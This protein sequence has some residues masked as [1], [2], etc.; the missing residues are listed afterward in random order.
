MASPFKRQLL[1]ALILFIILSALLI[2]VSPA[3]AD[4]GP[5]PSMDF[6]FVYEGMPP[7]EIISGTLLE[8]EDAACQVPKPLEELGPQRFTC[9]Q[10]ACHSMAYSYAPY[11]KLQIEFSDGVTPESG[12]FQK[13]TFNASYTVTVSPEGMTAKE[14]WGVPESLMLGLYVGIILAP[15]LL[16]VAGVAF[17]VLLLLYIMRGAR[18]RVNFGESRWLFIATWIVAVVFLLAGTLFYVSLPILVAVEALVAV[19]GAQLLKASK[20]SVFTVTLL[21]NLV[22]IPLA[23]LV[24]NFLLRGSLPL[25]AAGLW[26]G[27]WILEGLFLFLA[28]RRELGLARAFGLALVMNLAGL[29]AAA[30]L[31][32]MA[33]VGM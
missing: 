30:L 22:S 20:L 10:N 14:G 13:R 11:H 12:V 9:D 29:A 6:E 26:A 3:R 1:R 27:A 24:E 17:A 18:G 25:P 32:G 16:P 19:I 15:V 5:K 28:Q 33:G 2:P 23:L 21:A 7:Q 4:V 31:P 8:C